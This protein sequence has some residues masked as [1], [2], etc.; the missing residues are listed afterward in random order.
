MNGPMLMEPDGLWYQYK[1]L[2]KISRYLDGWAQDYI[3]TTKILTPYP[4]SDYDSPTVDT[5]IH[6][7]NILQWSKIFAIW[8]YIATISKHA[9]RVVPSKICFPPK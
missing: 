3:N 5:D 2:S 1:I 7:I 6:M 9:Y 4:I 8:I